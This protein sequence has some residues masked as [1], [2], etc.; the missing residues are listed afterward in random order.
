[1]GPQT[2]NEGFF[3]SISDLECMHP[4][5]SL[6]EDKQLAPKQYMM[7]QKVRLKYSPLS[8]QKGWSPPEHL[9]HAL[10]TR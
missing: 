1:M 5:K 3:S 6:V 8:S 10:N 9:S 7:K 2:L 4:Y